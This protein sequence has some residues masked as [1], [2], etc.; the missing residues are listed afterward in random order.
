MLTLSTR[1]FLFLA[2]ERSLE[3]TIFKARHDLQGQG[4]LDFLSGYCEP[5][6]QVPVIA[7]RALPS[8][9]CIGAV[10]NV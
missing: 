9:I 8:R 4:S 6:D 5:Q 7:L 2:F 10:G 3:A 1:D